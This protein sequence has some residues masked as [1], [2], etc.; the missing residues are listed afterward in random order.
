MINDRSV[1]YICTV[2]N[3]SFMFQS[4][5]CFFEQTKKSMNGMRADIEREREE[6]KGEEGHFTPV[7]QESGEKNEN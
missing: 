6:R 2:V 7:G 5:S 3:L 1:R 4:S